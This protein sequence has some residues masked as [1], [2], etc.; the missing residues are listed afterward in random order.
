MS[1][2]MKGADVAKTMKEDLTGEARRLKDRGILP[3]LTI[4]RVG[5]RPDDL[6]YERGARKRM[7]MIGIECKVVELPE[8][9]TQAEFEKTFFKI[10]EDPKVHGI[11]LFRPLPGHLDEGPVV[12]RINPLKDVDCMCPVNIAK[13]FSGDET[14]H[15][16]CTPEAVM[17]MLD[18]YK[19]DPK[20]KK[21][22]V[23]GRSMVVGKPLSM[24]LLKRHAT[25][26]I[27]HTRTKDLTA[28]C[29]EAEIL[30]AAAGKAR[31]VT[32]DMVGDG[33]VVVDVGINVDDKGNLCGDV[34]FEAA[35][36]ATSYISP[37]P[38][39]VGS[40]T[41]SVLAKHV[42]KAAEYLSLER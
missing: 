5:A 3:S 40:V 2:L 37:V 41:S 18:Y 20:G 26:T 27:C 19:I 35:E 39:G 4:V 42:L 23:I 8:T 16:P 34:D 14:G 7:E 1:I 25:V 24:M 9:I 21:V 38:R 6:A 11:L 29:R 10:N 13:V 30:V 15:A 36:P 17:E 32:A 28:T 12:S 22:T 33:A 31:M